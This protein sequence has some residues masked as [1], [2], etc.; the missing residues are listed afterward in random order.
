MKK[1]S[2]ILLLVA[3]ALLVF[4]AGAFA[5]TK[6]TAIKAFLNGDIK[7]LKDGEDWRPKD[8]RGQEV[9]PISYN[10]TIYLPLRVIA[11]AFNVPVSWEGSTQ[12]VKFGEGSTVTNLFSKQVKAEFWSEKSYD[13]VDKKQLVFEGKQYNG[14]YAFSAENVGLGW[15][16][17]SPNLQLDFGKKYETLHLVMIGQSAM[18]VRVLN[19]N[20]QQLAEEISLEEGKVTE[21]DIDLQG[22]QQ[23]FI[24]AYDAANQAEKP[25]LYILKD[26]YVKS[27]PLQTPR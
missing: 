1:I 24:S 9:L 11:N 2:V 17:G 4:S 12:T 25:L 5:A 8:D 16:E 6:V 22:S 21:I 13:I 7:F 18:K 20:K 19:E 26:S 15:Y 3:T 27:D 23:A 10:G 14:A